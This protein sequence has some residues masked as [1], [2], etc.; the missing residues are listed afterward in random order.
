MLAATVD[1]GTEL[2]YEV[3]L[4][5]VQNVYYEMLHAV[6]PRQRL[7]AEQGDGKARVWVQHFEA[8]GHKPSIR[9]Y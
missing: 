3:H 2:P 8:L 9:V 7:Q 5:K 1:L 4:W 6:Y